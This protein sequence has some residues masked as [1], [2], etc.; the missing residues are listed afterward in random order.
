MALL[1]YADRVA[2]TTTTTGTGTIQ[3]G[4]AVDGKFRTFVAG[5]GSGNTVPYVVV[6]RTANEWEVGYGVVTSGS[7][8]TLTRTGVYSSSN[9]GSAVNFSAGTKDVFLGLPAGKTVTFDDTTGSVTISGTATVG[10]VVPTANTVT[11]NGMYLPTTNTLAFS[12]NGVEGMRLDA[13]GNLGVGTASPTNYGAGY[14]TISANGTSSGVFEIRANDTVRG[15]IV[16]DATDL[17]I[18]AS[19]AT[20]MRFFTN[21]A[22]RARITAGGYFKASNNGTY[23]NATG[24]VHEF[25]T[26]IGSTCLV[27]RTTGGVPNAAG[28]YGLLVLLSN[29]ATVGTAATSLSCADQ[30]ATRFSVTT[31]GNVYNVNGTYATLSDAKLKQDI[32]DAGSQW[33]DLKAIRFRKYRLKL[34]VDAQG[35]DAPYLL[36]VVAQELQAVSPGLVDARPDTEQVEVE[37][38]V[39][40]SR[41]VLDEDGQPVLGEDGEPLTEAY[42]ETETRTEMRPTGTET[43]SVKQSILLMKAAVALQEAMARIETLEARLAAL[44]AK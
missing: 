23:L 39:E 20:P 10:K 2:E 9:G 34:D 25:T 1:T 37:V 30:N 12:T 18:Q 26:N 5:A 4:G 11:G 7:P 22:E 13:S 31:N 8:D 19:G 6:H 28:D 40:K 35:D 43:L 41:P 32:T 27:A 44:E 17:Q 29:V 38:E 42:T 14:R 21:A 24:A 33:D 36:G 3:L 15:L 16:G